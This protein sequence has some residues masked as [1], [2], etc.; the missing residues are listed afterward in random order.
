MLRLLSVVTSALALTAV[1]ILAQDS[2]PVPTQTV[3][4]GPN[5]WP[6]YN[7][8]VQGTRFNPAETTLTRE[9]VSRLKVEWV[10]P[11]KGDVYA[12][13]AVV[14]DIVYAGDTSGTFYALSR[15]GALQWSTTGFGPIT[16]SALVTDQMVIFGDQAGFIYGLERNKGKLVWSNQPNSDASSAIFSSPI[17]ANGQVIVGISSFENPSKLSTFRG[18][19]VSLDPNTGRQI[20]Q[21]YLIEGS[22]SGAGVWSTPTYDATTD[23]VY[24]TTANNHSPPATDT[25]DAFVALKG[26]DGTIVWKNQRVP[27]DIGDIK[28]DI[29]DSP[30]VYTIFSGGKTRRVIGAGEKQTGEYWV[31]D[32]ATGDLVG[33][34]QAVPSCEGS[35]GIFADSAVDEGEG[36]VFVNGVNCSIPS[37]PPFIPPTGAVVGLKSDASEKVWEFT[38]W[39]APVLSGVA[40][41]NGVVYFQASG[42]LSILYALDA[43]TGQVLAGVLTSGGISGPSVSNGQIYVGT[44]TKFASGVPTPTGI[45]ALGL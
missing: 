28:A 16:D 1:S 44:G 31:L 41:A 33:S 5:D 21:K 2:D 13:P 22:G 25:S 19:V 18:S 14:N 27:N 37:K 42:L 8:D 17:L 4:Q 24:V 34:I 29:G 20:W 3:T 36:M 10:F 43:K 30:Q 6:M 12:T 11:T 9:S 23:T 38:S 15:S 35:E 26:Q 7:H 45:V 39:F 32:A 40:V